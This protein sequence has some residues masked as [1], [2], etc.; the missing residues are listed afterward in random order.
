METVNATI[1]D[2]KVKRIY[3]IWKRKPHGLGLGPIDAILLV[4]KTDDGRIINKTFYCCLDSLGRVKP[5]ISKRGLA[6]QQEL[7]NFIQKYISKEKNYNIK[8]KI[9][10]WKGK[11]ITLLKLNESYIID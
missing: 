2:A 8:E 9:N 11:R 10:G 3:D 7:G 1:Q 5:S 6:K 4:I